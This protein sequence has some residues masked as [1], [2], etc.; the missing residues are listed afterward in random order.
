MKIVAIIQARMGSTRLPG[1]V[2]RQIGSGSMLAQVVERSRR[3][4]ALSEVVVATTVRREDD[5]IVEECA[6]LCAPV[7]RGSE[8][9][10]LDRYRE[11]ARARQA[12][13]VVRIT[14]D[15]PL[16]DAE[17][18]GR[19]V[20]AFLEQR[21]D[22][23]SNKIEPTTYPRGL[24]TEIMT[25]GALERAW[26]EAKEP[27]ERVHV[28]PFFYEQPGRVRALA[29]RNDRDFSHYRWTVDT[30]EDLAFVRA[31]WERL[32][33]GNAFSWRAVLALLEREPALA[34]ING[35]IVQKELRAG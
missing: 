14:A 15:C 20:D 9:D 3:A 28:T 11:A 13:A 17:V 23:A 7:T 22:Y 19:V 35:G 21:P 26:R 6:R 27:Y 8:L 16:I 34:E 1:K 33:P 2:L 25:R 4:P 10:V 31:V 24:D 12:E 30:P 32:G 29:V 18:I 5:R